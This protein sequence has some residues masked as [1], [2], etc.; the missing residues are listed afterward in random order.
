MKHLNLIKKS[1]F[2]VVASAVFYSANAQTARFQLIHNAADPALD[3]VDIYIDGNKL[4]NVAFRQATGIITA[5]SA[6]VKI[7]INER[8]S[9]D[10][11]DLVLV[12]FNQA[13][14]ANSNTVMMVTGVANPAN[15]AVNPNALNTG[16]KLVTKT[17]TTWAAS[18]NRVQANIFHGVTDAPGVDVFTRPTATTGT[19]PT[20]LRF[21]DANGGTQALFFNSNA[22]YLE[23][24]LT[25]TRS[26]IRAY[27]ANLAL[28]NQQLIT[29]FASGF[30]TPSA[31]QNG[32][33]FG[34]FAVDTNG[35]VIELPEA[36][37]IQ[38]IHNAPDSALR[39][40]DIYFNQNKV[41]SNLAF[42]AASPFLTSNAGVFDVLVSSANQN[43]TLIFVPSISLVSGKSYLAMALGLKDTTGFATNPE[44]FSRM[45]NI[46]GYD[47]LP[48]GSLVNNAFQYVVA[49]GNPD[50]PA[51]NFNNVTNQS[52]VGV[53]LSYGELTP[54]RTNNSNVVF[55]VGSTDK[56]K[57]N[58]AYLLNVASYLN[59]SGVVFTSGF[60]SAN[61]NPTNAANFRVM[62]ALNNGTV[63]TLQR[64][65]NRLQIVHNSPDTNIRKVDIYANGTKI[66]DDLA[67]RKSTGI[68]TSDAYVPVRINITRSDASDTINSIWS[69][70]L[71]PD[72][73]FNV[74]IAHGFASAPYRTNPESIS[75][76]FDVKVISPAK[77]NSS[78]TNPTN[79]VIFFHGAAN[80]GK[81][82][83]QGDQEPIFVA[84]NN[85][86][87]SVYKY[88]PTKGN[89]GA[90]YFVYDAVTNKTLFN[91]SVNLVGKS[92][93]AGVLF[94]S[95]VNLNLGVIYK[96]TAITVDEKKINYT[97]KR[98]VNKQD[99]ILYA[100]DSN[101]NLGFYIVWSN[102]VVDSFNR[103]RITGI[104]EMAILKTNNILV[105]PNPA[106]DKVSVLLNA[107]VSTNAQVNI[108][109]IKGAV[110]KSMDNKLVAGV[111]VM[112]LS[113][114]D[115]PKGMYFVQVTSNEGTSTKKLVIE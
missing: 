65:T 26:V 49:N 95:G 62:I 82:N 113:V 71:L 93:L 77:L 84:K 34:L 90:S 78:F 15:F 51:L 19:L 9:A 35:T 100:A 31:N 104:N 33:A 17:I 72:S 80:I 79:E 47:S 94:A 53:D 10:S 69:A 16:V 28:F 48:E 99:S 97:I 57:F 2:A 1:L 68:S 41:V 8:N 101:V 98:A 63:L 61:G 89:A 87:G 115:L 54:L 13:V 106:S 6:S 39:N 55:N 103:E 107:T 46:I 91:F 75:T 24:R 108:M 56:S 110:V 38:F 30:V 14:A 20:N 66:V 4:N 5:A 60:F 29:V 50:A 83:V 85:S 67:F 21:G 74:A 45:F 7:N 88:M 12:R 11:S 32:K 102:G 42:R 114:A 58:G 112:E 43:D 22:T 92:G 23:A 81:I 111:N 70:T 52:V 44:G 59:Q 27:N 73:N 96:D 3:T 40:V 86:Y 76:A 64:L 37:R 105:Y 25:G 18:A 109:D 36:T